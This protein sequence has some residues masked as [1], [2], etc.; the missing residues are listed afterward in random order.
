MPR[1]NAVL[2]EDLTDIAVTQMVIRLTS[3]IETALSREAKRRGTTPERLALDSLG[4][5]FP[6][7]EPAADSEKGASLYDFLSGYIGTV[8]G[9]GEALSEDC[10]RRFAEGLVAKH[11]QGHL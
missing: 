3:D 7:T 11:E 2:I 10:G 8:E 1:A 9:T 4:K 6:A 5:L